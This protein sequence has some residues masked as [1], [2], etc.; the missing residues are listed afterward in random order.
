MDKIF[1]SWS[2]RHAFYSGDIYYPIPPEIKDF[3]EAKKFYSCPDVELISENEMDEIYDVLYGSKEITKCYPC[4]I[5]DDEGECHCPFGAGP[6]SSG[7]FCRDNCG[8]GVG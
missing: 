3:L 1:V 8:L 4:D 7:Y 5:E 2:G 6:D